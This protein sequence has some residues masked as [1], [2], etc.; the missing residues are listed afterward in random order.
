MINSENISFYNE[1]NSAWPHLLTVEHFSD[2][3]EITIVKKG[4]VSYLIEGKVFNIFENQMLFIN[5][6]ILHHR[7]ESNKEGNNR[8]RTK[9][10]LR[11]EFL[12]VSQA[13]S[14]IS[15]PRHEKREE[16]EFDT[17]ILSP[18]AIFPGTLINYYARISGDNAIPFMLFSRSASRHREIIELFENAFFIF[19]NR[20]EGYELD[21]LGE[22]YRASNKLIS[23]ISKIPNKS[24]ESSKN[25]LMMRA[26]VEYVQNNFNKKISLATLGEAAGICRSRCCSIFKEYMNESANDY[27]SYYRLAKSIEMSEANDMSIAEIAACCGFNG[28]SYY[29]ELFKKVVGCTPTEYR[30]N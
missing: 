23:Y 15:T 13:E 30:N 19:N 6:N 24:G 3:Y 21:G 10:N 8:I 25:A 29:S 5:T 16:V 1:K 4:M 9:E 20:D 27:V 22:L 2:S 12:R 18:E 17:L 14:L 7:I 28:A 11:Q 26:M